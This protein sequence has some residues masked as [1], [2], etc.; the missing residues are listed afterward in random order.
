M[1][2]IY[3]SEKETTPPYEEL[4]RFLDI[5]ARH[6]ESVVQGVWD[7]QVSGT[8]KRYT[9][10]TNY[11]AT[12]ERMCVACKKEMHQLH[13]CEVFQR[14]PREERWEVIKNGY[15]MNCLRGGHMAN[16]C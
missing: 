12:P 11:A 10:R 6:H 1:D 8:D 2:R 15:C 13:N 16:K 5:Q 9:S 14:I 7:T 3:S 4:S